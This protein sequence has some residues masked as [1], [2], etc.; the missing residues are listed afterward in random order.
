MACWKRR[1]KGGVGVLSCLHPHISST[2]PPH[3]FCQLFMFDKNLKEETRIR[4]AAQKEA[5]GQIWNKNRKGVSMVTV[6]QSRSATSIPATNTK[7]SKDYLCVH[8]LFF[9]PQLF[10]RSSQSHG[11]GCRHHTMFLAVLFLFF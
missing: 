4:P 2:A 7:T 8:N 10:F 5:H 6:T 3:C 1:V 9:S 11:R